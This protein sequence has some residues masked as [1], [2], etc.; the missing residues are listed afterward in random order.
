RLVI[1]ST[2][3][4]TGAALI[5]RLDVAR[6]DFWRIPQ[7]GGGFVFFFPERIAS[8]KCFLGLTAPLLIFLCPACHAEANDKER[9]PAAP[10]YT[11][12]GDSGYLALSPNGHWLAYVANE[13]LWITNVRTSES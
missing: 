6:S 2:L 5:P 9:S 11:S 3:V 4:F 13:A 12:F 7:N 8:M 1:E 10:P